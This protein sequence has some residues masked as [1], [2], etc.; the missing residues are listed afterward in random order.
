M[1]TPVVELLP[2]SINRAGPVSNP[3]HSRLTFQTKPLR[4]CSPTR[5]RLTRQPGTVALVDAPLAS[6][7]QPPDC[8]VVVDSGLPDFRAPEV[9]M[10]R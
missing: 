5:H 2:E 1:P 7:V 9:D 6:A 8:G 10:A 4:D 3:I